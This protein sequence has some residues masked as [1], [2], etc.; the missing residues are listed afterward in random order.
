M[1]SSSWRYFARRAVSGVMLDTDLDIAVD[2]LSWVLSGPGVLKGSV[3]GSTGVAPQVDGR[4]LLEEWST[5]LLAEQGGQLRWA[6]IVTRAKWEGGRWSI[7]ASGFSTYPHGLP[8][9]GDIVST[10]LNALTLVRSI[11]A[12][13]Q[14]QPDGNLGVIVNGS[15]LPTVGSPEEPWTLSWWD[16]KDC[17]STID[18]LAKAAPFD[19]VERVAWVDDRPQLYIDCSPRAGRKRDDLVF[20]VGDNVMSPLAPERDGSDF[21]NVV[22]GLGAGEGKAMLRR[23]TARRDG[24][25]RRVAVVAAK[26]ETNAGVLD[27]MIRR[28][29]AER[30]LAP[31][32]SQVLVIDHPNAPIGS[33]SLGDDVL[34]EGFVPWVGEAALWHRVV[35]WSLVSE[36]AAVL[37]LVRSDP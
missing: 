37:Q 6:G 11:W 25:L 28:E 32:V 13:L 33:W 5:M 24:R 10:G 22:Y 29:L 14:A 36:S 35:G 12:Y 3:A 26:D 31:E 4:P 34:I 23:A 30:S 16:A 1:A 9:E 2:E 27:G 20:I 21:A 18:D 15:G 17:G 8:F 19:Y 7:E